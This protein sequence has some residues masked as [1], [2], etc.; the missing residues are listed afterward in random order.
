MLNPNPKERITIYEIMKHPWTNG[1]S[2]SRD[3]YRKEMN[4]RVK[5]VM[6]K[7]RKEQENE[8]KQAFMKEKNKK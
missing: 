8:I 3:E 2:M 6:V 4:V 7:I 1:E 5:K